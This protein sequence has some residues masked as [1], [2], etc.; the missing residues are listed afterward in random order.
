MWF[1][2]NGNFALEVARGP[3]VRRYRGERRAYMAELP[4]GHGAVFAQGK[5]AAVS[6]PN[7]ARTPCDMNQAEHNAWM[8]EV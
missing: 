7:M 6:T 4:P 2:A 8:P 1:F 3:G 5:E